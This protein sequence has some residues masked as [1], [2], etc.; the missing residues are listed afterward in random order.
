M[1]T[2]LETNAFARNEEFTTGDLL[3][4]IAQTVPLAKI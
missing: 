2:E 3:N 1:I 4:A